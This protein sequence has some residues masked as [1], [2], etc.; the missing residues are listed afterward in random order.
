MTCPS[1][2]LNATIQ[3]IGE[4][5]CTLTIIVPEIYPCTIIQLR[6]KDTLGSVIEDWFDY[7]VLSS[8]TTILNFSISTDVCT[9]DVRLSQCCVSPNEGS[10]GEDSD[11]PGD[12]LSDTGCTLITSDFSECTTTK[13]AVN[14]PYK[15][16]FDS[17]VTAPYNDISIPKK[18]LISISQDS[19]SNIRASICTVRCGE[20]LPQPPEIPEGECACRFTPMID[21]YTLP[22]YDSGILPVSRPIDI[23]KSCQGSTK[24]PVYDTEKY[25][26]IIGFCKYWNNA[27]PCID[28][29]IYS[30]QDV[31][32]RTII[33][34]RETNNGNANEFRSWIETHFRFILPHSSFPSIISPISHGGWPFT[35]LYWTPY[36][37]CT[38]SAIFTAEEGVLY[39]EIVPC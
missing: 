27:Y 15:R 19:C 26:K 4:F 31:H 16:P 36:D 17:N 30:L 39:V 29:R 9:I 37:S 3:R 22:N 1:L 6:Y 20:D 25:T 7:S 32:R 12:T 2:T 23:D 35:D 10:T 21:I 24:Y 5:N 8:L 33:K 38:P 18:A 28:G 14:E 11:D 34:I 13:Y